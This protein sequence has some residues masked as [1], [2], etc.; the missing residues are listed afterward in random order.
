M[1][2]S[3]FWEWMNTC[4]NKDWFQAADDGEG[5]R[6]YFPVDEDPEEVNQMK[7]AYERMPESFLDWLDECPVRFDRIKIT[8]NTVHYSFDAPDEE[9]EA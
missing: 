5:I 9:D 3:E 6:I 1:T 2:R 4:P 7:D 8:D